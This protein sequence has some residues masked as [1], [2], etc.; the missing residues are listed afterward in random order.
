MMKIITDIKN[1]NIKQDTVVTIGNFDGVHKGHQKI[2]KD[3]IS[4]AKNKKMKSVLFT[5]SNHPVNF[6]RK[7]K[8]KN[9]ITK[10]EKYE[11]I[12]KM[13]IDI[14]VSIPFNEFVI[15]LDPQ[16][17]IQKILL[18]KLNAKQIV[19]GH[20]FR[21]GLNRGGNAEFLQNIGKTYGFDVNVMKPICLENIR[22]SS[23]YIRSLLKN[24]EVDK[25][26]QFLGR[27][28][29]LKG[30]VVHGKKIGGDILGF[31][32]IN[33]KYDEN[34]LIP[35]TGVY[36]TTVNIDGKIYDGATNIGYSP[37]VK[38]NEFTVETYILKYSGDLYEK[39]ASIN[40]IRR[41]RD[42]IKFDTIQELKKQMN[43]DI[44]NIISYSL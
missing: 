40:F 9:I 6:F 24:G 41:I 36:Q 4:I 31:P 3:T 1:I 2:I 14:I 32:T 19:I 15:N 20:D 8:I 42:E 33:L 13:G 38:Q 37:T 28:Y 34:I 25:V 21:F 18:D 30:I 10:E 44:E 43:M 29:K 16:E 27:Q 11:I 23:T 12:N 17:Y 22:I 35:K 39:E 5:F 26:N 7:D